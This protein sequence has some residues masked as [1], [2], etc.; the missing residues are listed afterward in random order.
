MAL[1][2]VRDIDDVHHIKLTTDKPIYKP[3]YKTGPSESALI[4]SELDAMLEA[5][6]IRPSRSPYSSPVLLVKKKDGSVRFCVDYRSL[7]E[8]TIKDRYPIPRVDELFDKL[9]HARYFTSLD[10]R[11][12]Y[13]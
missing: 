1:P 12:G 3:P 11:S 7:N 5:G 10:L 6:V 13:W 8:I 4:K 9:S 2:H